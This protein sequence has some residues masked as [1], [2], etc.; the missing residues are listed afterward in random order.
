MKIQFSTKII[1]LIIKSAAAFLVI[2]TFIWINWFLWREFYEPL[3]QAVAIAE[4][5]SKITTLTIEKKKL[6]T[7]LSWLDEAKLP[8]TIPSSQI[9]NVFNTVKI[10]PPPPQ[11][12]PPPQ[13]PPPQAQPPVVAP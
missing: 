6:E 11:E 12:T 3:S 13:P 2:G 1:L 9:R 10:E 4:L 7:V 8:L 5:K